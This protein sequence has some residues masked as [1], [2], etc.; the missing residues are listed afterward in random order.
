MMPDLTSGTA[1]RFIDPHVVRAGAPAMPHVIVPAAP[2]VPGSSDVLVDA[3]RP[4][5][6]EIA[7][8]GHLADLERW[9]TETYATSLLVLDRGEV[10]HEW[11]AASLGPH[12][13]FLGASMTKSTL[14]TL[15][16]RAVTDGRLR[17]ADRVVDHVPELIGSGYEPCTVT[18]VITMT[19]GLDW[20]EDH[21]DPDGPASRLVAA[22]ATGDSSRELL[23][24][25]RPKYEPG[26]QW[27]YCT[28][29]S[30]V[31]DWVRERATGEPFPDALA[32]L[33]AV[34]GCTDDAVVGIDGD[35]AAMAGG[36]VAA[37][38]RDWARVGLL[39]I[40]GSV[41]AAPGDERILSPD[42]TDRQ[43]VPPYPFLA[44]GR[45]PST[46][47]THAGYAWHWW[48]MDADGR[49]LVADGSH[50]QFTLVDRATGVVVV[51]T[52]LWPYGDAWEDRSYR[53]LS[54]LGLQAIAQAVPTTR[55]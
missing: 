8:G 22:F 11:Y 17:L 31:L 3:P 9:R 12:T 10:V 26:T 40:D 25:T 14:A 28:A 43:G 45:L 13:R 21:R 48:P 4:F 46:Y 52:S 41:G 20:V 18:D 47:T 2:A 16:G 34:L 1:A 15:V 53:D 7:G 51:K 36:G 6:V 37:T 38:A 29:D 35:G 42:W 49:V 27:E 44:P 33:W 50:G 55:A 30:Q 24:Q 39:A 23:R 32:R 19:T 54:Y 5:D